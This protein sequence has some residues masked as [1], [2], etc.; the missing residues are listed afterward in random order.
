MKNK[1]S[2]YDIDFQSFGHQ[3]PTSYSS[4]RKRSDILTNIAQRA[5]DS[6]GRVKDHT[7]FK[8]LVLYSAL[9]PEKKFKEKFWPD[10]V[11]Y[12]LGVHSET[13]SSKESVVV[14]SI[15]W[16]PE[17]C[18]C[19]PRPADSEAQEFYDALNKLTVKD[20]KQ[21]LE[22]LASNSENLKSIKN[23]IKFFEMIKRYPKAYAVKDQLS[24]SQN[25]PPNL[26][27]FGNTV[28]SVSFPYDYDTS[29]GVIQP[30]VQFAMAVARSE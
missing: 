4:S 26:Y 14:E 15:V 30:N 16:I 20:K 21:S 29:I 7:V 10:I 19:L 27:G 13:K 3:A 1:M 11:D 17:L 5:I 24:F 2:F 25:S 22:N 12:V 18:S 8:G 28:V 6:S 23:G 9:L